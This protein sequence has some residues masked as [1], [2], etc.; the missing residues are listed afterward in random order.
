[1]KG[2]IDELRVAKDT[3]SKLREQN[4]LLDRNS[5]AQQ[6]RMVRL[7]ETIRDLKK[8]LRQK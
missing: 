8:A 4:R 5:K 1:M 6:E 2:L 7:E 3:N